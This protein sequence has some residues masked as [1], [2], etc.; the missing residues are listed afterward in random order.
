MLELQA[1]FVS[2]DTRP[3]VVMYKNDVP[4]LII[5]VHSTPYK[6]SLHKLSYVLVEQ[7]KFL[8]NADKS[9][10]EVRGFCFPKSSEDSCVCLMTVTWNVA[11]FRFEIKYSVLAAKDVEKQV[12]AV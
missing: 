5:E 7:L 11:L 10:N 1:I 2:N 9:I 12:K 4:V 6:D 8:K 3:D